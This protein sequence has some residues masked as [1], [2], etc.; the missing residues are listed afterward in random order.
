[1]PLSSYATPTKDAGVDREKV[2]E[3]LARLAEI[4]WSP[5]GCV[6]GLVETPEPH[7]HVLRDEVF[8]IEG[9]GFAGDH[10]RKSFYRG[11][12]VPGRE[13]TAISLDVLDVLGVDPIVVGDNLITQGIDLARLNEGD[14]VRVGEVELERT[15]RPHR[16]CMTFRDRTSPEAFAVVSRD[17]YRGALFNV[18]RGGTIRKGDAI[19]VVST[20]AGV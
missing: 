15:S 3:L 6:A 12:Y 18:R 14:V 9:R 8:A 13:V 17:G 5:E 10:G 16:P 4:R 20:R 11:S 1:M 7:R 19:V 2:D